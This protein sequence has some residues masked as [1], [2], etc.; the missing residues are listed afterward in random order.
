MLSRSCRRLHRKGIRVNAVCPGVVDTPML[1][2]TGEE[3]PAAWLG[4]GLASLRLLT[5]DQVAEAI[6]EIMTDE[7]CAGQVVTVDNPNSDDQRPVFS[8]HS[9]TDVQPTLFGGSAR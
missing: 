1:H 4:A 9:F 6:L 5:A 2:E 7:E 8:V 3:G